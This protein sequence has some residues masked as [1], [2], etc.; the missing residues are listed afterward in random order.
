MTKSAPILKKSPLFRQFVPVQPFHRLSSYNIE[1]LLARRRD[2]DDLDSFDEVPTVFDAEDED[3]TFDDV[4]DEEDEDE[5]IDDDEELEDGDEESDSMEEDDILEKIRK[6]SS[7]LERRRSE[8]RK[9]VRRVTWEDQY[10]DD[11]L[12][13]SQPTMDYEK[14]PERFTRW[15]IAIADVHNDQIDRRGE[16]WL[17]HM[18]W[19]RRSALLPEKSEVVAAYTRLSAD[20]MQP[21]GQVVILRSNNSIDCREFMQSEPLQIHS[22][23]SPWKLY[24]M[25]SFDHE[26]T[27]WYL[28]DPTAYIAYRGKMNNEAW[29][30]II[31]S[32]KEYHSSYNLGIRVSKYVELRD[33]EDFT[34]KGIF[35]LLNSKTLKRAT[36]YISEDP[37]VKSNAA[38]NTVSNRLN[39][40]I[41]TG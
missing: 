29:S 39:A 10:E 3:D 19:M 41:L 24:E 38:V 11:P 27:T 31:H 1:S 33:T 9:E 5:D 28:T 35:V 12:T 16:A 21:S 36:S 13:S 20:C 23:V 40:T 4:D 25:D 7:W 26:N 34:S 30:D 18:Q 37:L 2:D 32:S 6:E 17:H 15:Y 22:G 8:K 14:P